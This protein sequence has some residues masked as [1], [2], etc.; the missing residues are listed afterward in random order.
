MTLRRLTFVFFLLSFFRMRYTNALQPHIKNFHGPKGL[1]SLVPARRPGAI[2]LVQAT[3]SGEAAPRL[4]TL[5]NVLT[6]SRVVAIPLLGLSWNSPCFR[7]ALF[8]GAAA[9]DWLDGF[10]ARRMNLSSR[11]GAFLDPVA[12]KLMVA[13][14]LVLLSAEWGMVVAA[15]AVCILCREIGITALRE[16]MAE[17]G[18]R[19]IVAVSFAGKVKTTAQLLAICV[20]LTRKPPLERLQINKALASNATPTVHAV[21]MTGLGLLYVATA[22]T[23]TS[24]VGYLR[25]AWPVLTKNG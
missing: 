3:G 25:A 10:L 12:D 13:T 7:S 18:E 19:D 17:S 21:A 14:A 2:H 1:P 15:P 4:W 22:C 5:P 11:F 20:L 6:M 16:W 9:T 8:I 24:G 23:V